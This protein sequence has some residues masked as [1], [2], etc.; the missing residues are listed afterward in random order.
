[1]KNVFTC[2]FRSFFL[3]QAVGLRPSS[4]D[5][6]TQYLEFLPWT[7]G[8]HL[9]SFTVENNDSMKK[10]QR[11]FSMRRSLK[12]VF[13][14]KTAFAFCTFS[15]TSTTRYLNVLTKYKNDM[16]LIS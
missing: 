15:T 9:R 1:M 7:R 5:S 13:L 11:Y 10:S 2:I 12:L 6:T 14:E 16:L 8:N 4:V 3:R